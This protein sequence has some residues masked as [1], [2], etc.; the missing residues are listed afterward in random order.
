MQIVEA[1][2]EL[3]SRPPLNT[4]SSNRFSEDVS[5]RPA[6]DLLLVVGQAFQSYE[7]HAATQSGR[8]GCSFSIVCWGF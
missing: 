1:Y 6:V 3:V 4:L 8:S 5:L 2:E 7:D